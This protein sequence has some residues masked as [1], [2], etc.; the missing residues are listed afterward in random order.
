MREGNRPCPAA[1]LRHF[2][3]LIGLVERNPVSDQHDFA[4]FKPL[5][6]RDRDHPSVEPIDHENRRPRRTSRIAKHNAAG[7]A[8][9][10]PVMQT[11]KRAGQT[12]PSTSA[13]PAAKT[14][15]DNAQCQLQ[16][17]L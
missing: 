9:A 1:I 13:I 6:A 15:F 17:T 5:L 2:K 14:R 12:M 8:A 16:D 7:G 3:L 10:L 11:P 4:H